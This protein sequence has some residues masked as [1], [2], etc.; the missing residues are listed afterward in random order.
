MLRSLRPAGFGFFSESRWAEATVS[1]F[2]GFRELRLQPK[3]VIAALLRRIFWLHE[4]F[5]KKDSE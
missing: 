2:G 4:D 5:L 1:L 3:F